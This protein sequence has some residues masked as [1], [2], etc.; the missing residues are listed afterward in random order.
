[1]LALIPYDSKTSGLHSRNTGSDILK[2]TN[3]VQERPDRSSLRGLNQGGQGHFKKKRW[4][5]MARM[6]L[7]L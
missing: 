6:S 4:S 2:C 1:M 3:W 7:L 5:D